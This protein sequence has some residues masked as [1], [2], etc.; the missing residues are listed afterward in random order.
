MPINFLK[1]TEISLIIVAYNSDGFIEKCIKSVLK[2]LPKNSEVIVL[3]NAST[4]NTLKILQK[5]GANIKLIKSN[6]NLGFAKGNNLALKQSKGEYLFFLNPDTEVLE[7]VFETLLDFYKKTYDAGIIAPKLIMSDGKIQPSVKNL[8]TIRGAFKEY[9]LGNKNSYSEYVPTV[10]KPIEV[11]MVYGA[12]MLIKRELFESVGGFDEGYFIY[13]ED[14]DLCREIH[15][16]GKK[17]YYYPGVSIKHM[18][19]GV[20]TN[21]DRYKLNYD[22][23]VKYHGLLGATIL[24][25]IFQIPRIKRRLSL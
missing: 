5:F 17:I 4:D 6:K 10:D 25:L 21:L 24:Q 13:Y 22:S 3:D 7:P 11:G 19:G 12:A 15:M 18:V 20:K 1:M 14:A 2:H 23:F 9:I 16:A 8:P